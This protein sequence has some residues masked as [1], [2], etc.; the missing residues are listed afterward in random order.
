MNLNNLELQGVEMI[1]LNKLR[2][3]DIQEKID[4]NAKQGIDIFQLKEL[5]EQEKLDFEWTII[6]ATVQVQC[7]KEQ[8]EYINKKIK[9]QADGVR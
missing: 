2:P 9:E 5:I 3:E 4:L 6:R 8:L 7:Y 1:A